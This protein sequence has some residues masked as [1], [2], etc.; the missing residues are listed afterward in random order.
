MAE[1]SASPLHVVEFVKRGRQPQEKC[2]DIVLTK[3][4]RWSKKARKLSVYFPNP[5]YTQKSHEEYNRHLQEQSDPPQEWGLFTVKIRAKAE[6]IDEAMAKLRLIKGGNAVEAWSLSDGGVTD[7]EDR[8]VKA[9]RQSQL[10][11]QAKQVM[12]TYGGTC[13]ENSFVGIRSNIEVEQP[14]HY[15]PEISSASLPASPLF[16]GHRVPTHTFVR[17][18]SH[19]M[20]PIASPSKSIKRRH[21]S[22]SNGVMLDLLIQ[23]ASDVKEIKDLYQN[24]DKNVMFMK[25]SMNHAAID[26][27][28]FVATEAQIAAKYKITIPIQT[29]DDFLTFDESLKDSNSNLKKDVDRVLESG[30]DRRHVISRSIVTMLK[31]FISRNVAL[32]YVASKACNKKRVMKDTA[33]FKCMDVIIRNDRELARMKTGFKETVQELGDVLT[34]AKQWIDGLVHCS[35]TSQDCES[36]KTSRGHKRA[37]QEVDLNKFVYYPQEPSTLSSETT[38]RKRM[39]TIGPHSDAMVESS[40]VINTSALDESQKISE[41]DENDTFNISEISVDLE[42]EYNSEEYKELLRLAEQSD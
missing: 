21:S 20:S 22:S 17:N 6:N 11:D 15:S 42:N 34:N 3:S 30:L 29:L 28:D 13:T 2:L 23:I 24:L 1:K 41:N 36:P 16:T 37:L 19:C 7:A 14:T 25:S 26:D 40:D 27:K 18:D 5:P 4:L 8:A 35:S 33:F 39:K 38:P 10:A 9:V 32:Q 31:M 12:K